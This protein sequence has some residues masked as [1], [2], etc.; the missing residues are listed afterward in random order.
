MNENTARGIFSPYCQIVQSH[1][2][3]NTIIDS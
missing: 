2:C 1:M 3:E